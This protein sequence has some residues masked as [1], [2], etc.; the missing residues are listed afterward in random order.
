MGRVVVEGKRLKGKWIRARSWENEGRVDI[1]WVFWGRNHRQMVGF[2]DA[3]VF[4]NSY[5]E[6]TP[7]KRTCTRN[8]RGKRKILDG[9]I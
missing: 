6:R 1:V 7:C 2:P 3:D 8:Q 4:M 5:V 9:M